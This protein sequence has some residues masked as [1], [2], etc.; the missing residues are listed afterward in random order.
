[1]GF[2][3]NAAPKSTLFYDHFPRGDGH[4]MGAHLEFETHPYT[5]ILEMAPINSHDPA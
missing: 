2:P 5:I 4:F 1:M 3:Q